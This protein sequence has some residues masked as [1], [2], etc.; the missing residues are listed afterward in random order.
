MAQERVQVFLTDFMF[1]WILLW[2]LNREKIY[3]SSVHVGRRRG[4]LEDGRSQAAEAS[5]GLTRS[6]LDRRRRRIT[7]GSGDSQPTRTWP[8]R[9]CGVYCSQESLLGAAASIYTRLSSPISSW[10]PCGVVWC[11]VQCVCRAVNITQIAL[12]LCFLKSA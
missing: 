5:G 3:S 6:T 7:P 10:R 9:E 2:S 12:K 1:F 4:G 8:V 11:G